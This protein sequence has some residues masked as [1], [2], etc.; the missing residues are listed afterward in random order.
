M[1]EIKTNKE[2]QSTNDG[3]A[4]IIG[5]LFV[6]ALVFATYSY[7][8]KNKENTNSITDTTSQKQGSDSDTSLG[9]KIKELFN[10]QEDKGELNG[11]GAKTEKIQENQK[12]AQVEGTATQK[13]EGYSGTWSANDYQKGEITGNSYIVKAGD[14]LWELAEAKYGNGYEWTKILEANTN[15]IGYLPG[16]EQALI[17]P[18]Q[19]L[20]L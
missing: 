2:N 15:Q 20:V 17:V 13:N 12:L 19:S 7:F 8:N 11:E 10:S 16:G 5:G 14:T 9:D 3:L 1:S 6:L 18:G 4:L